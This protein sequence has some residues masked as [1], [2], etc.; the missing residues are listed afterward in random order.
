MHRF[1]IQRFAPL[2]WPLIASTTL[3]AVTVAC[4]SIGRVPQAA[5]QWTTYT[6]TRGAIP[7]LDA[8]LEDLNSTTTL[9]GF[10]GAVPTTV[11]AYGNCTAGEFHVHR[12]LIDSIQTKVTILGEQQIKIRAELTDSGESKITWQDETAHYPSTDPLDVATVSFQDAIRLISQGIEE[13]G[14]CDQEI[15]VAKVAVND[16]SVRCGPPEEVFITCFR[17]DSDTRLLTPGP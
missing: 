17:L 7:D 10:D 8:I 3:T 16:W 13:R 14:L 11:V 2:I 15:T 12:L 6:W 5:E 4:A 1:K 9:L